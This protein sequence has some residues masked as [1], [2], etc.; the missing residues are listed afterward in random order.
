MSSISISSPSNYLRLGDMIIIDL[1]AVRDNTATARE[2]LSRYGFDTSTQSENAIRAI[3][4]AHTEFLTK[5]LP[6]CER[7]SSASY[8][9]EF[10]EKAKLSA[11]S[12]PEVAQAEATE[13]AL[14]EEAENAPLLELLKSCAVPICTEVASV[15]MEELTPAEIIFKFAVSKTEHA[16][17]I[18]TKLN[19]TIKRITEIMLTPLLQ[20]IQGM[21]PTE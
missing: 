18:S 19:N 14:L 2:T 3:F 13:L 9:T 6:L 4:L 5:T 17:G 15:Y 11:G 1:R 16:E 10:L 20:L 7:A 8:S 21:P 12:I